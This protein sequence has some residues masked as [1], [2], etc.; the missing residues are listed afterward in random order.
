MMRGRLSS[1]FA[2]ILLCILLT[3]RA[4][5]RVLKSRTRLNE[6]GGLTMLTNSAFRTTATLLFAGAVTMAPI[7]PT[8]EAQVAIKR[9]PSGFNLFSVQQDVDLGRQSA[10]EVE[11]QLPM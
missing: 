9:S 3:R 6:H 5:S 4:F 1:S 7:A 10:I 8:I 11:K 2:L